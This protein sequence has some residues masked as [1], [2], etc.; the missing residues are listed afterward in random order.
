M[1]I[2]LLAN[3]QP[4][5]ER[6]DS[7]GRPRLSVGGLVAALA[8]VMAQGDGVW[9]AARTDSSGGSGETIVP[10]TGAEYRIRFV[11]V[12]DREYAGYYQGL[13][14]RSLWPLFHSMIPLASFSAADWSDYVTVN[15]RFAAAAADEAEDGDMVWVHDYQLMLVP[16]L[17]RQAR[18]NLRI[19]YF[20]HIPFPS[21]EVFR[22]FPW[23]DEILAGLL[24]ADLVGFHTPEYTEGFLRSVQRLLGAGV[25]GR[26]GGVHVERA[27]RCVSVGAFP[28]GVDAA[29]WAR[30]AASDRTRAEARRL[31]NALHADEERRVIALGVDRLDYTKGILERLEAI[32]R[33]LKRHPQWRRHFVFVQ[34][35]VPSRTRV[36]EYR[37]MKAEI[38]Q[39][40][41]RINGTF[42]EAGWMPIRYLY[43]SID[44]T[45]LAAYYA[46]ADLAIV[47]PLRDGM[48]LVAKEYVAC[49]TEF[50][51]ALVLSELAGAAAD[52]QGAFR[53]NPYHIDAV[54][55]A[56]ADALSSS[57]DERTTRMAQMRQAV[58]QHDVNR[59]WRQFVSALD[60]GVEEHHQLDAMPA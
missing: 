41:G 31:R 8:P 53:V 43:R 42:G 50:T 16:R 45:T 26:C 52:L 9:I 27:D 22:V 51:G 29:D 33:F 4:L 54:A 7:F 34:I 17:L 57:A 6:P 38:E 10:A 47:T 36:E 15:Q 39:A 60:E 46:A 5:A 12:P 1:R 48:N 24:G 13:A 59:W 58:I 56:I 30:E 44:R 14:N 55:D 3:R 35:A 20:H 19:G 2:I 32:E 40:V 11:G 49:R 18:P 37:R 25:R 28:I 21:P 23:R